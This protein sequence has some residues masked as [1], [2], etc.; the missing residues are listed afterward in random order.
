MRTVKKFKMINM[1]EEA[2]NMLAEDKKHFQETIGGGTW[3]FSD[4]IFE[5]K[6]ILNMYSDIKP[7]QYHLKTS[8]ISKK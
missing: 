2:Y 3:S 5:Y 8:K 7:I 6:K 1:T 4:V